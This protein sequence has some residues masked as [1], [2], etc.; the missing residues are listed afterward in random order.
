LRAEAAMAAGWFGSGTFQQI[1]SVRG[2][3][4]EDVLVQDLFGEGADQGFAV[5]LA[6]IVLGGA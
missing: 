2:G 1:K 6:V 3:A 5:E 4:G